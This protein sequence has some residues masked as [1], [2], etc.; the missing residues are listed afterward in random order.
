MVLN[1]EMSKLI[2]VTSGVPQ[3]SVLGPV[4]FLI[5][6]ND[7]DVDIDC[8]IKKFA[9][10]TKIYS[11]VNNQQERGNLQSN[12]NALC[13][14][15]N[16]WDMEFN[17]D[18]CKCMK[19]GRRDNNDNYTYLMGQNNLGLTEVERDL[20]II[21]T[22]NF[23]TSEQCGTAAKKANRVLGMIRRVITTRSAEVLL[24]LYKT[25]VRPHLEYA[26]QVWSPY[27]VK[28]IEILE[29]V[30]HRFTRMID[31][32][33][34]LEY[35]HRLKSLGLPSLKFRRLQGDLI[36]TFKIIKG[37][38]KINSEKFFTLSHNR[39]TRGHSLKLATTRARILENIFLAVE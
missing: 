39:N 3:G 26:V 17:V 28:D 23:K 9:D 6:I 12:I 30:Q 38:D 15:A 14:W 10:D 1:G 22:S 33:R 20:G 36:E 25:L 18:K 13:N 8:G 31:G 11:K 7:L 34:D 16:K 37:F 32:V 29:R 21:T 4:L 5:F 27:L 24:P 2:E 19:L 35:K